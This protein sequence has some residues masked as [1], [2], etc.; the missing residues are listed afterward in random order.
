MSYKTDYSSIR[1]VYSLIEQLIISFPYIQI[2]R[3]PFGNEIVIVNTKTKDRWRIHRY[4]LE[5][6]KDPKEVV[7]Y[8]ITKMIQSSS[9]ET[10]ESIKD[11][12]EKEYKARIDSTMGGLGLMYNPSISVATGAVGSSFA[13]G[14]GLMYDPSV[15]AT[16]QHALVGSHEPHEADILFNNNECIKIL[17]VKREIKQFLNNHIERSLFDMKDVIVAGGCFA[18]MINNEEIKDIDVFILDNENNRSAIHDMINL[19]KLSNN[20]NAKVGNNEYMANEKIEATITYYSTKIQF[21]VTRYKTREELIN[22]FDFNH[23]CVSYDYTS[24]KLFLS[25]KTFDAIKSK[26]LIPNSNRYPEKWR[27]EKFWKRGWKSEVP[28]VA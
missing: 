25:R 9:R 19:A 21:I 20:P 24:D 23:C 2:D 15:M 4:E 6:A 28:L 22:H 26:T 11:T 5:D 8:G 10:K 3:D 12:I 16:T 17:E 1:D 18:S 14:L 27:Y 13:G 7:M